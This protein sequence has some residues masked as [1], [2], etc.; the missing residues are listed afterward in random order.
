MRLMTQRWLWLLLLIALAGCQ[1][2]TDSA[3]PTPDGV[4]PTSQ[5]ATATPPPAGTVDPISSTDPVWS[6]QVVYSS[7]RAGEEVLLDGAITVRFDQPMDQASVEAALTVADQSGQPAGG[8]ISWPQADTLLFTPAAQFERKQA[9]QLK[10]ASSASSQTGQPLRDPLT[11]DFQTVGFLEVA[12][13][14]PS[15]GSAEI[16]IDSAVTVLF[17]RPVV[18]LTSNS[19]QAALPQPISITPE[20]AGEG[21]WVSTS[22]YRFQP[23]EQLASG[24][25]YAVTVNPGLTDVTGGVLDAAVSAEFSTISPQVTDFRPFLVNDTVIPT[26]PISITFNM[27]MDQTATE[28]AIS[29]TP[30]A[31]LTSRWSEDGRTIALIPIDPLQLSL[32]YQLDVSTVALSAAGDAA[33]AQPFTAQFRTVPPP[34]VVFVSPT[35][36]NLQPYQLGGI[37]IE[38][39]APIDADSLDGRLIIEPTPRDEPIYDIFGTFV[40]VRVDLEPRTEY[41]ITIPETVADP[42]GNGLSEPFSWQFTTPD[43]EPVVTL[44]LPDRIAMLSASRTAEIDIVHRKVDE[45]RLLMYRLS[46]EESDAVLTDPY[47]VVYDNS[48]PLG[49]ATE[50][51]IAADAEPDTLQSTTV[52]LGGGGRL[53]PGLYVLELDGPSPNNQPFNRWLLIVSALNVT[54]REDYN[55]Q[56]AWVTTLSDGEPAAGVDVRF[57]FTDLGD[58]G[59][60]T[61][62][63]NGLASL[64][65]AQRDYL[66]GSFAVTGTYGGPDFGVGSSFWARSAEPYSF[67]D[68]VGGPQ[69]EHFVYLTTDRPIYRPGDVVQLRGVVR[70]PDY[71]RYAAPQVR[72]VPLTLNA[73]YFFGEEPIRLQLEVDERGNIAGEIELSAD[74]TVGDYFFSVDQQGWTLQAGNGATFTV[75]EYRA[76]EFTVEVRT[77]ASETVRGAAQTV[78][79]DANY[80]FGAPAPDL[81]VTLNVTAQP[82]QPTFGDLPYRFGLFEDGLNPF[83]PAPFEQLLSESSVTDADGTATFNLPADLLAELDAGSHTVSFEAVVFD[84]TG[85]A[86]TGGGSQIQHAADAY[87]GLLPQSFINVA[88]RDVSV[89]LNT[90]DWA[91]NAAANLPVEVVFYS[92]DWE[93]AE[94]GSFGFVQWAP[95]D[96]EVGRTTVTS[97]ANGRATASFVPEQGGNYAIVATVTDGAGRTSSSETTVWVTDSTFVPWRYDV[98]DRKLDLVTDQDSYAVGDSAEILIQ[99]PFENPTTAWLIV[100]RGNVID[101]QIITLPTNS[102]TISLPITEQ[103]APNVFVTVVVVKPEDESDL[104]WADVRLGIVELEVDPAPLLLDVALSAAS[105]T[106]APGED[107]T[108]DVVVTNQDGD[109][110]TA[111]LTLALVDEGVLSL[112]ADNQTIEDAFYAAQPYRSL[113]GAT[114]FYSADGAE[115]ELPN[116]TLGRGGGGGGIAEA[117]AESLSLDA[118]FDDA[119]SKSAFDDNGGAL[120]EIAVRDDFRDTAYWEAL[121]RTDNNGRATVTVPLP[122]NLTTW[123]L[124]AEAVS[125]DTRVGENS[126]TLVAT[127][128]VLLRPVTPRFFTVGDQAEIGAVVNNNSAET[129][130]AVVSVEAE[131]LLFTETSQTVSVPPGGGQIVRFPARVR[132]VDEVALTFRVQAG[133]YSDATTPTFGVGENNAIPVYR[134]S[135]EDVVGTSGLIREDGSRIEAILLPPALDGGTLELSVAGSLAGALIDAAQALDEPY[136]TF[137]AHSVASRLLANASLA[138]ALRS[139]NADQAELLATLDS[140]IPAQIELLQARHIADFGW[141][142][143]Y[144]STPDVMLTAQATHALLLAREAGYEIDE[145]ILRSGLEVM[146]N[147]L[148]ELDP[149]SANI[150]DV[151]GN[152]YI[153]YVLSEA[154]IVVPGQLEAFVA[155]HRDQLEPTAIAHLLL[156]ASKLDRPLAAQASLLSDLN[157]RAVLSAAGTHWEPQGDTWRYLGTNIRTTATVVHA[158]T[159]VDSDSPL[160][161][162]AVRWLMA[163]RDT[164]RWSSDY[165]TAATI[166]ALSDW[167]VANNDLAPTF[168]WLVGFDNGASRSGSFTAD[169]GSE[170]I[171]ETVPLVE[172]KPNDLNLLQFEKSGDGTLYYTAY[173]DSF[174]EANQLEPISRGFTVAR[175]IMTR[176]VM[177]RRK[178]VSRLLALRWGRRCG[179]S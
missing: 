60:V 37:Q 2:S 165:E 36:D 102:E 117:A 70:T 108:F 115:A 66:R 139:L 122:D 98:N 40:S 120:E 150:H 23:S 1:D 31:D 125:A 168:D 85:F 74:A 73:G 90:F 119:G 152:A 105:D 49:R 179:L 77:D 57:R 161:A 87:V 101:Q 103:F 79:V 27:P 140:T 134:Y 159:R 63:E 41:T 83:Q 130:D 52:D 91:G 13:M 99:T 97:D 106:V 148:P 171:E 118:A 151:S 109:A 163:A 44:P 55:G 50:W 170:L 132:D 128:P 144:S 46:A 116:D 25:R 173:L 141:G 15:D 138:R 114:L 33:L 71:G 43:L 32:V 156:A 92:R 3:T 81:P 133:P 174:I 47:R 21:R 95:V 8:T 62:D 80:L 42:Y 18:P 5:V 104:P 147:F 127:K 16:D 20:V 162:N 176:L 124:K 19:Q 84:Q 112:K 137:C 107:A 51:I 143:C 45:F 172:L 111:D 129:V 110:V 82:Y 160:L 12:Q 75:A 93:P 178:I 175:T 123:R 6:P 29:L 35:G 64:E 126:F 24:T 96:S 26:E 53:L 145:A 136:P 72:S 11:L 149:L 39:N 7:P 78:T 67:V 61:T 157:N 34:E 65:R 88:E 121:I 14:V 86:V 89:D 58:I 153:L 164:Q 59:T 167:M 135:G 38:F 158:L 169:S 56:T 17:N 22:I 142:Y 76:P 10:I 69:G 28:S 166:Y 146:Q 68:E 131:G 54:V 154:T 9:Y 4:A 30:P 48:Y 94:T 100:E 113:V 177:P 155:D